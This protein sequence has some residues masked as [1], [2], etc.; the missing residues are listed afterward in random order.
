MR[1]SGWHEGR[2]KT[3]V[4][5]MNKIAGSGH[6]RGDSTQNLTRSMMTLD[7]VSCISREDPS[8]RAISITIHE[9]LPLMNGLGGCDTEI[10]ITLDQAARFAQ[11]VLDLVRQAT[12]APAAHAKKKLPTTR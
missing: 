9:K 11:K 5:T 6:F 8:A 7:A 2:S 12:P 4:T 10:Q 1:H 3:T